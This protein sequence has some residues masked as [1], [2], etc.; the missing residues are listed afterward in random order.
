MDTSVLE[1]SWVCKFFYSVSTILAV[2]L[3]LFPSLHDHVVQYGSRRCQ[4]AST[5]PAK[6]SSRMLDGLF[7]KICGLQV[8][9]SWF[10]HF[11]WVSVMSSLFWGYQ[12]ITNGDTV[13][14]LVAHSPSR[15]AP[16]MSMDQVR[17]AWC[18][19]LIQ[20]SRRLY[21]CLIVMNPSKSSMSVSMWMLGM[22]YYL[23][24]GVAVWCEGTGKT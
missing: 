1:P 8:P 18:L 22:A 7:W 5:S 6:T 24:T 17:L 12:I 9:H 23:V 16:G 15:D 3:F 2:S 11:Y 13:Q 4:Q 10:T 19:M 14:L 20:G 21:E